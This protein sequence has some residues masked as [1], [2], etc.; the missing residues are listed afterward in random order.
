[1]KIK[2][3]PVFMKIKTIAGANVIIKEGT[4]NILIKFQISKVGNL[5]LVEIQKKG[6][7]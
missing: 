3:I 1:M 2:T 5:F 7:K 6:V 4:Y